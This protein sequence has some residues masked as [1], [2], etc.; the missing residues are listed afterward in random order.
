[1]PVYLLHVKSA[2]IGCAL[3]LGSRQGRLRWNDCVSAFCFRWS[4]IRTKDGCFVWVST[5]DADELCACGIIRCFD[6]TFLWKCWTEWEFCCFLLDNFL[7][8]PLNFLVARYVPTAAAFLKPIF[9]QLHQYFDLLL[10]CSKWRISYLSRRWNGTNFW[11]T[12][13][14][15]ALRRRRP[16]K[17]QL[18]KL[19][20]NE[21]TFD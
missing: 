8:T 5:T 14:P 20:R 12:D 16:R 10:A 6:D 9:G 17:H 15:S 1:M 4:K 19:V 18:R 3:L 21:Y 2:K 11:R 7:G 13:R